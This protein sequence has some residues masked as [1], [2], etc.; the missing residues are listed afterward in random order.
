MGA[1]NTIAG[2]SGLESSRSSLWFAVHLQSGQNAV[3]DYIEEF[4][5]PH[6]LHSSLGYVSPIEF[7]RIH[8]IET[9]CTT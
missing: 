5:N 3:V 7:E 6:R 4:Y 1:A 9:S 8:T 2:P